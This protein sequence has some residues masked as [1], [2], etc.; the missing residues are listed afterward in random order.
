MGHGEI[1][2]LLSS[3]GQPS[4]PERRLEILDHLIT[5]WHG[6][7][8]PDLEQPATRS[9]A[10]AFRSPCDG[11]TTGESIVLRS[12]AGRTSCSARRSLSSMTIAS[13]STWKTRG[14]ISGRPARRSAATRPAND[15]SALMTRTGAGP[16]SGKPKTHPC[17]PIQRWPFALG[18]GGKPAHGIPDPGLP[19]RGDHHG[20]SRCLGLVGRPGLAGSGHGGHAPAAAAGSLALARASLTILGGVRSVRVSPVR[21]ADATLEPYF[22]VWVGARA[23]EPLR[24]LKSIVDE[25][26][27]TAQHNLTGGGETH[28]PRVRDHPGQPVARR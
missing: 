4:T 17:G 2:R 23:E 13:A 25:W 26:S 15:G 12:S 9:R 28:W 18:A 20:F 24:Y 22:S 8:D 27:G 7:L 21:T 14:S 5:Y 11:C 10:F 1:D 19:V 16:T 6:V 3:L